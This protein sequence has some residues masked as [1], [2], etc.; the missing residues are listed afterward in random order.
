[1][2]SALEGGGCSVPRPGRFTPGKDP[3]PIVQEVGWAPGPVWTCAKNASP[4]GFDPWTVQSVASPYTDWATR[5]YNLYCT[6]YNCTQ[7]DGILKARRRILTEVLVGLLRKCKSF[8]MNGRC[9]ILYFFA[10]QLEKFPTV[11]YILQ[12]LSSFGSL[13]QNY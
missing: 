11:C 7:R 12:K 5:P 3:V 13:P 8:L 10:M 6:S 9:K 2:T 4:L 1:V